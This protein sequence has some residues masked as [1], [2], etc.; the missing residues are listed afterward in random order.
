MFHR[1]P[2]PTPF[3][4]GPVN[5]Y[6]AGRTIVD[7]G[8]RSE[9]SWDGV[10]A[11]LAEADLAPEDLERV[12][13]THPHP[14]HFGLAARLRE[15]GATVLASQTAAGIMVDFPG[16]FEYEREFFGDFFVRCGLPRST[17][18][19]VTELPQS[20]LN[21]APSVETDRE[22]QSGDTV[23]VEGTELTVEETMGHAASEL[24]F[25]YRADGERR[26]IVGDHVLP[27]ITP[28]PQLQAPPTHG[29]ERPRPLP[30]YNDSLDRLAEEPYDRFLPGHREEIPDPTGRIEDIRQAHE[31]RTDN[32]AALIDGPTTAFDVMEGLFPDLPATEVFQGMSEAIGHLDVLEQR[33]RATRRA[34]D[35]QI[36]YQLVDDAE[37]PQ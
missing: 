21:Y 36:V 30:E 6:L 18:D 32:V 28:N 1:T 7:P 3:R 11:A 31:A 37:R 35:D 15:A 33:G 29:G 25:S 8:P 12:I 5:A 2:I 27:K 10:V 13:I 26:A 17:A 34:V 20:F 24:L 9:E 19:T 23:A 14:D 4:V 22:L 16:H